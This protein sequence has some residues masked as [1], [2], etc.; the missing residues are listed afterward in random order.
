MD[1]AGL[2]NVGIGKL[3]LQPTEFWALSPIELQV[4]LGLQDTMMPMQ[5]SR[6]AALLDAYPDK[7]EGT[8][9]G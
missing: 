3:G 5:R 8:A 6:M 4:M 2:V 7:K 9:D 1:W